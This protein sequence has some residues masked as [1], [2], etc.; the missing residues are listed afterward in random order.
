LFLNTIDDELDSNSTSGNNLAF[1]EWLQRRRKEMGFRRTIGYTQGTET[2]NTISALWVAVMFA[3][4]SGFA[5]QAGQDVIRTQV[6]LV[7][8]PAT[9]RDIP[10]L[11][12]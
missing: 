4:A 10:R 2:L 12:T 11:C 5:V 1:E 8:V 6:D 3:I 9:I 7:V